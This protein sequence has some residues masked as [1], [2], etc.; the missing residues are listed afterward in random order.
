MA[1]FLDV[2]L[3]RL[4]SCAKTGRFLIC[5]PLILGYLLVRSA[6]YTAVYMIGSSV[7]ACS[8]RIC[9]LFLVLNGDPCLRTRYSPASLLLCSVVLSSLPFCYL[10][11]AF[12]VVLHT[13]NVRSVHCRHSFVL[14]ILWSISHIHCPVALD[15]L[16]SKFWVT[17]WKL[18]YSVKNMQRYMASLSL[19]AES[20]GFVSYLF[21]FALIA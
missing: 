10:C 4:L 2:V 20:L 18:P 11:A 19:F 14:F 13:L 16:L 8:F 17:F 7:Y 12:L 5:L 15:F 1:L 21:I 6:Y 9:C 3:C